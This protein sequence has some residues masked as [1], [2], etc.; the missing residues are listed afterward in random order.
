MKIGFEVFLAV[1]RE[2]SISQAAKQL[3]ITPQCASDHIRRLE[4]EYQVVLFER[5]PRFHLTTAGEIMLRSL[6]NMQIVESSMEKTLGSVAQG[7]MGTFTLGISTSRAPI[8]LPR[9]LPRYYREF[10]NVNISFIEEDTQVLEDRLLT[11]QI[12]LFIGVNTTPH[13]EFRITTMTTEEIMLVISSGLLHQYFTHSEIK[14]M[15]EGIDLNQFSLIP[16]TLSVKTGKVNHAIQEYLNYHN[17]RLSAAYNISDSETQIMLCTSGICA[18][19]CP[20][21]LLVTAHRHNL[22]C[23]RDSY[24]YMFPVKNLG[25]ELRIDLVSHKNAIH[26]PFLRHFMQITQEEVRAISQFDLLGGHM[27]E[28]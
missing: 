17:V 22:S 4:K 21:M 15:R 13:S 9:V 11:G 2:L 19:L 10:P 27:D 5:K 3:H 18:A 24:L 12:D 6:Q 20:R 7:N 8:I 23:G 26:P 14:A 25:R 28:L 16:F 1:A